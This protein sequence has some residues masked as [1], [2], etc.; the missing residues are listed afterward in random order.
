MG[1]NSLAP[2][3]LN[4]KTLLTESAGQ[5]CNGTFTSTG[6]CWLLNPLIAFSVL[7]QDA[8]LQFFHALPTIP[9]LKN[10]GYQGIDF[11]PVTQ[12][13]KQLIVT[14]ACNIQ[15]LEIQRLPQ[16]NFL[17]FTP[18]LQNR[19]IQ[20]LQALH[21]ALA[22]SLYNFMQTKFDSEHEINEHRAH[23]SS[24]MPMST[25]QSPAKNNPRR[26]LDLKQITK[27]ISDMHK[28]SPFTKNS[29]SLIT[30]R[31][32]HDVNCTY[33]PT[34][35]SWLIN[36]LITFSILP[37]LTSLQFFPALPTLTQ[38]EKGGHAPIDFKEVT[39]SIRDLIESKVCNITPLDIEMLPGYGFLY[40]SCYLQNQIISNLER[41]YPAIASSLTVF[42]QQKFEWESEIKQK[43]AQTSKQTSVLAMQTLILSMHADTPFSRDSRSLLNIELINEECLVNQILIGSILPRHKCD[44]FYPKL[45][46]MKELTEAGY[47]S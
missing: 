6:H 8:A 19:V 16:F 41:L 14:K 5:Y 21:P 43:S 38:L 23:T 26:V 1:M 13:I 34:G 39:A 4:P 27:Y 30:E 33:T 22:C 32:G 42:M 28:A 3:A 12:A 24:S 47:H 20:A 37:N 15:L 17:Y 29:R 31:A 40:Y 44:Q 11:K 10:C 35:N 18:G 9:Q 25:Q 45:P 2:F 46:T 36:P 7:S